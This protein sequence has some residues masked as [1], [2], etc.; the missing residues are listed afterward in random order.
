MPSLPV[1]KIA[2]AQFHSIDRR[3]LQFAG[4]AAWSEEHANQRV[5]YGYVRHPAVEFRVTTARYRPERGVSEINHSL[6]G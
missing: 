6:V 2:P 1:G 5:P 3:R 4:D